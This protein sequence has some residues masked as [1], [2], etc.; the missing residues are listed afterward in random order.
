MTVSRRSALALGGVV[1]GTGL[2]TVLAMTPALA[3]GGT[4]TLAG[5]CNATARI[6]SQ[7]GS[8]A[9]GGEIVNVTV[10][11]TSATAATQWSVTGTLGSGQRITSAWNAVVNTTG[12]TVTATNAGYNGHLALG[13][14]TSFGMQLSGVAPAPAL[15]CTNDATGPT[16]SVSPTDQ[17]PGTDVTVT[18][19]DNQ[20]TITLIVGQTL[21]VSLGADFVPPT[22]SGPALTKVSTSGGFPTGQ[23]LN[24]VYRA[25]RVGSAEL[26]SYTDY[27]CR[28]TSPPCALP[29]Q[30]WTL[31]VN[32][33]EAPST[34]QTVTV[35]DVDNLK[36]VALHI[37]DTLVVKLQSI[38]QPPKVATTG[39][40]TQREV[41]GGYPTGQPL[42]A[43]YLATASG[44]TDLSSVTD[45]A[46]MHQPMPCPTPQI[47]WKL[48][49]T[50][51]A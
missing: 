35:T 36:T 21:G 44:Q 30:T 16:A 48:H 50:V 17:A 28:H 3:G 15:S 24:A 29:S 22:V 38:Y 49:V 13:G 25:D 2:L 9:T 42:V 31:H 20:R 6:D 11:N 7:W 51:T 5:G 45:A 27:P 32:V 1:A 18:Q 8:G 47:S 41:V 10:T 12:S 37:G 26:N 40:L 19:A 34:G 4:A 46:C 23:P 14:S 39:V 43:T 33:V